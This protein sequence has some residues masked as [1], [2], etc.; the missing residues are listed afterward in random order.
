MKKR[1][2]GGAPPTE[3]QNKGAGGPH[4]ATR[5]GGKLL[6]KYLVT[7]GMCIF[8]GVMLFYVSSEPEALTTKLYVYVFTV[9]L[10][11]FGVVIYTQ[12]LA[13]IGSALFGNRLVVGLVAA[14]IVICIVFALYAQASST[15]LLIVS[16]FMNV[17]VVCMVIVALMILG[18]L[19]VNYLR[20]TDNTLR[21][22]V[23]FLFYIPCLLSKS[24]E[25]LWADW[26]LTPPITASLLVIETVL[27]LIYL[28]VPFLLRKLTEPP[29]AVVLQRD[30]RFLDEGAA[31]TIGTSEI[32]RLDG[33]PD[34]LIPTAY[35][36][37][38]AVSMWISINPGQ[39][40]WKPTNN[41][42]IESTEGAHSS[43]VQ[44]TESV[45]FAYGCKEKGYKPR[46][47]YAGTRDTY[48]FELAPDVVVDHV[49][50]PNQKWNHFVVNYQ[51]ATGSIDIFVNGQLAHSE[52]LPANIAYGA[53]DM[54]TI[55]DTHRLYGSIANVLYYPHSLSSTQIATMWNTQSPQ[56]IA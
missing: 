16:V 20:R 54:F 25:A 29:G 10:I 18:S 34:N 27:I 6:M 50:V 55:G 1:N 5:N 52:R 41:L 46:I 2:V 32:T 7:I 15:T 26:K 48:R 9:L 3:V 33:T 22:I 42:T 44:T 4:M 39:V 21:F 47:S 23:E 51:S 30:P 36:Q 8:V 28:Y 35:R 45:I 49:R 19:V 38:Y 53:A 24:V 56:V 14:I 17:I 31:S 11:L 12:N 43:P 37:N 40:G 13:P